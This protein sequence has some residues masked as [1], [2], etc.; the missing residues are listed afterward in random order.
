MILIFDEM[1]RSFLWVCYPHHGLQFI[2]RNCPQSL[3]KESLGPKGFEYSLL[4]LQL[5]LPW[6][7]VEKD[8]YLLWLKWSFSSLLSWEY[9][10]K[11]KT[12]PESI[13]SFLSLPSVT[14]DSPSDGCEDV[15]VRQKPNTFSNWPWGRLLRA[16]H[17]IY[18]SCLCIKFTPSLP[19]FIGLQH[20]TDQGLT[21]EE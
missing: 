2:L 18:F 15:L 11:I 3:Y 16:W 20:P 13:L 21:L 6:G 10:N 17:F 19:A 12:C 4:S 9:S 1:F 14:R 5:D 8:S 7:N